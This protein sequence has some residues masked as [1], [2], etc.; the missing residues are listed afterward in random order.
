MGQSCENKVFEKKNLLDLANSPHG[1]SWIW[2]GIWAARDLLSVGLCYKIGSGY[3]TCVWGDP[4]IPGLENF[5]T[6]R[7]NNLHLPHSS[8]P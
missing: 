1:A 7:G 3:D 4:W 8:L 5:R 6:P 2:N